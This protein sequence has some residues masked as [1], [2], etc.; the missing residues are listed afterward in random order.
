ML[1]ITL[2]TSIVEINEGTAVFSCTIAGAVEVLTTEEYNNLGELADAK[3]KEKYYPWNWEFQEE[4]AAVL[5]YGIQDKKPDNTGYNEN[6]ISFLGQTKLQIIPNNDQE[7]INDSEKLTEYAKELLS[8]R[9]IKKNNY[10]E[11]TPNFNEPKVIKIDDNTNYDVVS[12]QGNTYSASIGYLAQQL[13]PLNQFLKLSFELSNSDSIFSIPNNATCFIIY[14]PIKGFKVSDNYFESQIIDLQKNFTIPLQNENNTQQFSII[15]EITT[16]ASYLPAGEEEDNFGTLQNFTPMDLSNGEP[17]NITNAKFIFKG[18]TSLVVSD[19]SELSNTYKEILGII[20][21]KTILKEQVF[22]FAEKI[23]EAYT[24]TDSD[25]FKNA[26]QMLSGMTVSYLNEV[27]LNENVSKDYLALTFKGDTLLNVREDIKSTDIYSNEKKDG[28]NQYKVR[29]ELVDTF[30][31]ILVFQKLLNKLSTEFEVIQY[32]EASTYETL[33]IKWKQLMEGFCSEIQNLKSC[34]VY[35]QVGGNSVNESKEKDKIISLITDFCRQSVFTEDQFKCEVRKKKFDVATIK[36]KWVEE[37]VDVIKD[38]FSGIKN[39]EYKFSNAADITTLQSFFNE[40]Q[41]AFID[42]LKSKISS[43]TKLPENIPPPVNINVDL[44]VAD[45]SDLSDEISG[46]IL[47]SRRKA[48][49]NN[50]VYGEWKYLNWAKVGLIKGKE[51][52]KYLSQDYLIPAVLPEINDSQKTSFQL[53]NESLSLV[54]GHGKQEIDDESNA[55]PIANF[56]Y[57]FG[58]TDGAKQHYVSAAPAFWY[59]YHYQFAGFVALNSGALPIAIRDKDKEGNTI[60]NKPKRSSD[61]KFEDGTETTTYHHLRRVPI[62]LPN[63]T[64]PGYKNN[65]P[66]VS[67]L[68][69]ELLEKENVNSVPMEED[70]QKDQQD[71][72]KSDPVKAFLLCGKDSRIDQSHITIEVDKPYTNFWNWYAWQGEKAKKE[73]YGTGT[74]RK[75]IFELALEE[76][77]NLKNKSAENTITEQEANLYLWEPAIEDE[78]IAKVE[79]TF[80]KEE[81]IGYIKLKIEHENGKTKKNE[82]KIQSINENKGLVLDEKNKIISISPGIICKISIHCKI[83]K[84][85]FEDDQAMFHPWMI[86]YIAPNISGS[87]EN[88]EYLSEGN[89]YLTN[90]EVMYIETAIKNDDIPLVAADFKKS[91]Y[92]GFKPGYSSVNEYGVF[93]T[94]NTE[95]KS[96]NLNYF[97]RC[98]VRHQNWNWNGRLFAELTSATN[99]DPKAA[100]ETTEAMKW[101]AWEFAN[102]P[103]FTALVSNAYLMATKD[104]NVNQLIFKDVRPKKDAQKAHYFRF[105]LKLYNRYETIGEGYSDAY[106]AISYNSTWKRL[107]KPLQDP[108][109]LPKPAI[110]FAIPLT[111]ALQVNRFNDDQVRAASLMIATYDRCFDEAGLAEQFEVGI[112]V[113][114]SPDNNKY[115]QAGEDPILSGAGMKKLDNITLE[116]SSD[117][118]VFAVFKPVGPAALT[119]DMNAQNPKVVGSTFILNVEDIQKFLPEGTKLN[120]YAMAKIAIRRV[121][122]EEFVA[123][124]KKKD[125][126]NSGDEKENEK[127]YESDWSASEWVQFLPA[128]DS[129]IPQKWKE[130]VRNSNKTTF[131]VETADKKSS[132]TFGGE[133]PKFDKSF[134]ERMD[135]YLVISE[136]VEDIGGQPVEKYIGVYKFEREDKST[137]TFTLNNPVELP[138]NAYKKETVNTTKEF[139]GY[140]RLML[141]RKSQSEN[142][143]DVSIW[144]KLFGNKAKGEGKIEFEKIEND[145]LAAMPLV[146][147]RISV[148]VSKEVF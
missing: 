140:A 118:R 56:I 125:T 11:V 70:G 62:G 145:P 42:E 92:D 130:D 84:S 14:I 101:E 97:S 9:L 78:L 55:Q 41:E 24:I 111:D 50:S 104:G 1:H 148:M 21:Y 35:L 86:K 107:F 20:D 65:Y 5:W 112:E 39:I 141:V 85:H 119:F 138:E 38:K 87:E 129:L 72:K 28:E 40:K 108:V 147:K 12:Q 25:T 116:E 52:P 94:L 89:Y 67:L 64:T 77:I 53:S 133:M 7:Y 60:W 16:V 51:E 143:S 4:G 82:L 36:S 144:E 66:G 49:G 121:L 134:E 142:D 109:K 88:P 23:G 45:S 8:S 46:H 115:L 83:D 80:P 128:V 2:D 68:V 127:K 135:R 139:S 98:E 26:A 47:L 43:K 103:D 93:C 34:I 37:V 31:D 117:K 106:Q 91:L 22:A 126:G 75:S 63:I 6:R 48:P 71:T 3:E 33:L 137:L 96:L 81:E 90:P 123:S 58:Y 99:L 29:N 19:I 73:K 61:I 30:P 69:N 113:A 15:Q 76:E 120:A 54:A 18:N 102:R 122:K 10:A 13:T 146:S 79:Q 59:G 74:E 95:D 136:R 105:G 57:N 32:S 131:K 27:I 124:I 100:N 114:V 44:K 17:E 132:V 110:R